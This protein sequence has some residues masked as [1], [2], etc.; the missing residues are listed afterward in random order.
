MQGKRKGVTIFTQEFP[1]GTDNRKVLSEASPEL[2]LLAQWM[3]P[4]ERLCG[5]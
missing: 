4:T 5:Q 1:D 2:V 3:P